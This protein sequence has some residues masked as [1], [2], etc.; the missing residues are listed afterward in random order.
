MQNTFLCPHCKKEIEITDALTQRFKEEA[1]LKNKEEL[2]RAIKET[3]EKIRKKISEEQELTLKDSENEI[4]EL[5]EQNRKLQESL[6]ELNKTLREFKLKDETRELEMQKKIASE[7]EKIKLEATK[8]AEEESRLKILEL[9]KQKQDAL[10]EVEDMRRKL[11]QG[12]QQAQGEVLELDFENTL[13]ETF[14]S[15]EILPIGKGVRG[16]DI[17]QVVKTPRGTVCGIILWETKRT[18]AWDN[19]WPN[20]LKNELRIEKAHAPIIVSDA[21]PKELTTKFGVVNGVYV[22]DYSHAIILAELMRQRLIDIARERFL[23][24]NRSKD[25]QEQIYDY[26]VSR[27]FGQELDALLE[28]QLAMVEQ[29]SREKAAF[30][31]QWKARLEISDKLL[32]SRSRIAG[33]LQIK[34]G[35]NTT[36]QIKDSGLLEDG[37]EN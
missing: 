18:R 4:T 7:E 15:D 37:K 23:I 14:P 26:I 25:N 21:F 5:K 3:E 29:V 16:A 27:E 35:Q 36:L 31:K 33:T 17:K 28:V 34:L 12:S 30:E 11:Q 22:V 9:E 10:K 1:E 2:E 20:K 19:D 24:E 8:K 6:L 32:K 13:R